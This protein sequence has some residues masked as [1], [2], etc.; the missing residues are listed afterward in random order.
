MTANLLLDLA[1]L[2]A[3]ESLR[4]EDNGDEKEAE[5]LA[6]ESRSIQDEIVD[7]YCMRV[8]LLHYR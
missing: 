1:V 7:L 8:R 5:R 4:A 6:A 2:Y 3:V